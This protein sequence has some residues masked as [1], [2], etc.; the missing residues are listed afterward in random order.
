MTKQNRSTVNEITLN[1]R[2]ENYGRFT[3]LTHSGGGNREKKELTPDA[4]MII[5][6]LTTS[7]L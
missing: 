5:L 2:Q 7:Q 3:S 4:L 1:S 6:L